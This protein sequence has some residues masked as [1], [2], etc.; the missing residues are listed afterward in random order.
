MIR[1]YNSF[2]DIEERLKVLKREREITQVSLK[3]NFYRTLNNLN[4]VRLLQVSKLGIK[5]MVLKFMIKKLSN[6]FRR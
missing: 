2:A 6:L 1:E 3:L 4:P 5:K